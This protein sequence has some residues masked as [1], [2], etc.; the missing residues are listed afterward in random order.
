MI[1]NQAG[2]HQQFQVHL[3]HDNKTELET[4]SV[5]RRI[6]YNYSDGTKALEDSIEKLRF[7]RNSV[8]DMVSG[9]KSYGDWVAEGETQFNRVETPTISGF[10]AD[11]LFVPLKS[12]ITG[13]TKDIEF[14]VV[15]NAEAK[16]PETTPLSNQGPKKPQDKVNKKAAAK[17]LPKTE[18]QTL[19]F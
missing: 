17:H 10:R 6:Y 2:V 7:K 9:E 12:D 14:T 8:T 18:R 3:T 15:Y 11:Q 5:T 13:N 4:K 16:K 19:M 1:Y